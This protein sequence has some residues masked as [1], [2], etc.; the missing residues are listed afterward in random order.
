MFIKVDRLEVMEKCYIHKHGIEGMKFGLGRRPIVGRSRSLIGEA[1]K[2]NMEMKHWIEARRCSSDCILPVNHVL[3]VR[4]F[5][6]GQW[7]MV[8]G[9]TTAKGFQGTIFLH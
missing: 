1:M 4:H 8:G 2:L 3:S 9:W 5:T 7:V 6:P